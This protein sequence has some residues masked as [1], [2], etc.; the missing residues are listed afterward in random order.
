MIARRTI[1]KA[2]LVGL[3]TCV[4]L[5]SVSQGPRVWEWAS[6]GEWTPIYGT[7]AS[8]T[9]G[10]I[11][12]QP[13]GVPL[14]DAVLTESILYAIGD[15]QPLRDAQPLDSGYNCYFKAKKKIRDWLPG[16]DVILVQVSEKEF[17]TQFPIAWEK[18]R[19][20]SDR[21]RVSLFGDD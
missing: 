13:G 6:Y 11:I 14:P 9:S 20:Q 12:G 16:K 5:V 7:M 10:I 2:M 17:R 19:K 15:A 3:M 1:A 4:L 18:V 21:P 8:S